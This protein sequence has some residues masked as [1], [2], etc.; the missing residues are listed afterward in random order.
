MVLRAV[1]QSG[2]QMSGLSEPKR[3][4]MFAE[5]ILKCEILE[6]AL[7]MWLI[8]SHTRPALTVTRSYLCYC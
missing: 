7:E 6:G 8:P 4:A 1:R 3:R 2:W 5:P